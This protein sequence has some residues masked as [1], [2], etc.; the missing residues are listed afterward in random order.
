MEE[1][2]GEMIFSE[3]KEVEVTFDE[4]GLKGALF[5]ATILKLPERKTKGKALVEYKNLVNDSKTPLIESVKLSF[6]RPLP[7]QPKTPHDD[8]CFEVN[9]VVDAFDLDGWWPGY[10]SKVF[11][12][13]KGY[14]VSFDDPP[15]V[16]W[17]S[18][19]SSDLR[20]HWEWINGKWVKS[21][22]FQPVWVSS[23]YQE[24]VELSCSSADDA[25][26]SIQS[27]S[28]DAITSS[29]TSFVFQPVWVSSDSQE[30]V[31]LTCSSAD[32]SGASIQCECSNAVKNSR[33][34]RE[35]R[36]VTSR[37]NAMRLSASKGPA[38]SKHVK[39]ATPEADATPLH[40]SKKI[41]DGSLANSLLPESQM[42][43]TDQPKV[44][45]VWEENVG[46]LKN[47]GRMLEFP[48][49]G[50]QHPAAE[51]KQE[52]L[53]DKMNN[54]NGAAAIE[55][56]DVQQM[57]KEVESSMTRRLPIECMSGS[58]TEE[59]CHA[60]KE[61]SNMQKEHATSRCQKEDG[62]KTGINRRGPHLVLEAKQ[63]KLPLRITQSPSAE[64]DDAADALEEMVSEEHTATEG[65]SSAISGLEQ[66]VLPD[67]IASQTMSTERT[68]LVSVTDCQ[69]K[70]IEVAG[71]SGG[72]PHENEEQSPLIRYKEL[73][74]RIR[75]IHSVVMEE[76]N[77][78]H[79]PP[80]FE[81]GW[82]DP[83]EK[84][85]QIMV[86]SPLVGMTGDNE[87]EE[88]QDLPFVKSLPI[89]KAIESMEI[90]QVM[91]QNPHFHPLIKLK[92][93]LREGLAIG[94]M[95]SFVSLVS[96]A[97]NLTVADPRS[98]FTSILGALLDLEILGFDVKAIR[99]RTSEFLFMKD[100]HGHLQDHSKEVELQVMEHSDELS[101][102]NEEIDANSKM[103]RE[104]EEKQALLLSRK[105]SEISQIS[106]L[107]VCADVNTQDIQSVEYDFKSLAGSPW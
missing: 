95:L 91:P 77:S 10:I 92:E 97:W 59:S 28:S 46:L 13:P 86:Q 20:P 60:A 25:G 45:G 9:D 43:D 16:I 3:G 32:D 94:H 93:I 34:K 19:S 71:D 39:R 106:S 1:G 87:P 57:T 24:M 31:E 17:C 58:V 55:V 102:I 98:L 51:D 47:C 22:K 12:N 90:F 5:T 54:L 36:C 64:N 74:P 4:E 83:R 78:G 49:E 14:F 52:W 44:K 100:R 27:E 53:A 40:P 80:D 73:Q 56:S 85:L 62:A 26:A 7:P 21:S 42:K 61:E 66:A 18:C 2:D 38:K 29:N 33:K 72:I 41:K 70:I 11:D 103:L 15:E 69:K 104:L 37:K 68:A 6:I 48:V 35:L 67:F 89:W 99:D 79:F 81:N 30:M 88:G 101:K 84:S 8:Q 50:P 63:P 65:E 23:D 105:K 96:R 82:N 107:Q 76:N 75:K